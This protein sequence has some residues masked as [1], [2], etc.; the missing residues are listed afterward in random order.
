MCVLDDDLTYLRNKILI[1][2]SAASAQTS[3]T[4]SQTCG[5]PFFV[6][7]LPSG[8]LIL[9]QANLALCLY[10]Y[11]LLGLTKGSFKEFSC[12]KYLY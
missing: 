3:E 2:E 4:G 9:S 7:G 12:F 6:L 11:T 10:F 1:T 8:C 5:F